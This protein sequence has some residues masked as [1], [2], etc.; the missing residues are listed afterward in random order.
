M[1]NLLRT[2]DVDFYN[3]YQAAR[4]IKDYGQGRS[5]NGKTE[6][7]SPAPAVEPAGEEVTL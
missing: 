3:E 1:V 7:P 4:T 2:K 5:A 6:E